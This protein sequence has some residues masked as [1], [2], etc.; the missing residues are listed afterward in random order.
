[1][2]GVHATIYT[3][4]PGENKTIKFDAVGKRPATN[5]TQIS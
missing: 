2:E 5:Y 4:H 3:N 1:M